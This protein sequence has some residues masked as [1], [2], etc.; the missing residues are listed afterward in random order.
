MW[1][2]DPI[3][4]V[5]VAPKD[6][7]LSE[8]C[9]PR[10]AQRPR[11]NGGAARPLSLRGTW[12]GSS[13]GRTPRH[14][15]T[16]GPDHRGRRPGGLG[17]RLDGVGAA[18]STSCCWRRSAPGTRTAARTAAP[19]SSAA[20]TRIPCTCGSPAP[21]RS[22]GGSSRTES[23][24]T[25]LTLTGGVDFGA[26]RD[27]RQLHEVLARCG[28]PAELLAPEAAAER[29]PYFDFAGVGQVMFHAD[30][31]VLDPHNAMAAMLRLATANG[32]DI[33]F[34]TPVTRLEPARAGDGAVAHTDSGTFTAP[35]IAVAAGAWIAPLL[36]GVVE[37]PPPT[38][39][40]QQVFH[41]APVS[42]PENTAASGTGGA[43][44]DLRLPGRHR[45][46]LR[47]ARRP[48]RRGA[49]RDQDRRAR[50]PQPAAD[51]RPGP[52]LRGGS[53]RPRP[54]HRLRRQAAARPEPRP[55]QRG[56]LPL[57]RTANEDFILDRS[58]PFVVASPC[59][60]HGAKFAPLLGKIIADLAAG[61]PPPDPRF[62]LAAHRGD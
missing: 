43:V 3:R 41:F 28:V 9:G 10:G 23:G 54:D 58:G 13:D 22:G 5:R 44:A 62:T 7:C 12:H 17:G 55:G 59:S 29:W 48:G 19:G 42:T 33:R 4:F 16:R 26:A 24:E 15:H 36:D 18:A 35:V 52:R 46:L 6:R 2:P 45:Q 11:R 31:G 30:A 38:V 56:H 14:D 20:P 37:L 61:K 49:R 60:G 57:H 25:L 34:G 47:P 1:P 40:Q 39:T 27:P 8:P 32:A 21:Q 50:P 53:G 51:D